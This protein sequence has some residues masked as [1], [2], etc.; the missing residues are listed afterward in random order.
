M[1]NLDLS[2]VFRFKQGRALTGLQQILLCRVRVGLCRVNKKYSY[3]NLT[4]KEN[5]I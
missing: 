3:D 5:K 4:N 1:I 2:S